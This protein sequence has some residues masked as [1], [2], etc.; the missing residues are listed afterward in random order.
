MPAVTLTAYDAGLHGSELQRWL[1]APHVTQ[2]WGETTLAD[3]LGSA[4]PRDV[5]MISADA[6]PVGFLRWHVL[7]RHE[8]DEAGLT[9][10]TAGGVDLDILI[11]VPEILGQGIGTHALALAIDEITS[12]LRPPFFS[13]CTETANLRALRCYQKS[14]FRIVCEFVELGKSHYFLT[15]SAMTAP[16]D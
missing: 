15:R 9:E 8:L 7:T 4:A 11:G 3:A 1:R 5:R 12:A 16:K 2:W 13:L 6:R 14:G 10:I